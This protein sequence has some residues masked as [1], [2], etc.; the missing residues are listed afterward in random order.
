MK[1]SSCNWR[2]RKGS[3]SP[4]QKLFAEGPRLAR[5]NFRAF[6][7]G[8]FGIDPE[9]VEVEKALPGSQERRFDLAALLRD[10]FGSAGYPG[11]ERRI[12]TLAFLFPWGCC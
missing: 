8:D 11:G 4:G 12:L 5:R 9:R 1:A 2:L 10:W 7:R 6:G 3:G